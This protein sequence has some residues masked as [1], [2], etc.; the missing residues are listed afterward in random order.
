MT[1]RGRTLFV[2]DLHGCSVEFEALLDRLAHEAG[3]D[4]LLLVGDAFTRGPDPIGVWRAI[5][6]TRA[7]M[8][9]GNHDDKVLSRLERRTSGR[10]DRPMA[11]DRRQTID[12]LEPLADEILPWLRKVPLY[13]EGDG[14]VLVHAGVNPEKG[15]GGTTRHEFLKIRTWP[16]TE[17]LSAPRWHDHYGGDELVVF[18][19]DAPGGLVVKRRPDGRPRVVGLDTG[20]VYGGKLT[21]YVLEEDRFVHVDSKQRRNRRG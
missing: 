13:I 2:G 1:A 6:R 18:G 8:V 11:S 20:C 17:D 19:H 10:A 21:A 16:E 12:V 7:E 3:R 14:W 15:L 5:Q 9:L 4:R